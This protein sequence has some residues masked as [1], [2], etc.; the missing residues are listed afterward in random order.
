M[1]SIQEK[2]IEN[3][4]NLIRNL[5]IKTQTKKL[6][7]DEYYITATIPN[8]MIRNIE[9]SD[10][11]SVVIHMRMNF[12]LN[13]PKVYLKTPVIYLQRKR[14]LIYSAAFHIFAM[15]ETF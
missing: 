5:E 8:R 7:K 10:D 9:N 12:P 15:E 6:N 4:L 13:P 14:F 3:E 1:K 11:I 2:R